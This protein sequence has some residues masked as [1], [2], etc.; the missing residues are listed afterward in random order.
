MEGRTEYKKYSAAVVLELVA[1]GVGGSLQM[2]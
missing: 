1:V 2:F